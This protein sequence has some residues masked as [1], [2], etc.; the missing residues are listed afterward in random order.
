MIVEYRLFEFGVIAGLNGFADSRP[1]QSFSTA[2]VL[3]YT[4]RLFI[5]A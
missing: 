2:G 4:R 1:E 5:T 3:V